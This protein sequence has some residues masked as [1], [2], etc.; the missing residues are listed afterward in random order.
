[1]SEDNRDQH[2]AEEDRE[3]ICMGSTGKKGEATEKE[4][5]YCADQQAAAAAGSSI[6]LGDFVGEY[7]AYQ[8]ALTLALFVRY[9][10][11]GLMA[12]SGPLMTPDVTFYCRLPMDEIAAIMP[13]ITLLNQTEQK[14]EIKEE[15]KRICQLDLRLYQQNYFHTSNS[16]PTTLSSSSSS[17]LAN[18]N[19]N[20]TI[21]ENQVAS[22]PVHLFIQLPVPVG[23]APSA[24]NLPVP[25]A[26]G[27]NGGG[28]VGGVKN[29][30]AFSL[31]THNHIRECADFD[32]EIAQDQGRTM[33][34]EFDLVC[35]RDWLR[36]LFQSL[37]SAAIVVAHVICGTFSDKYGR[38]KAQK[39]CLIISLLAGIW[40]I[41]ALDFWTFVLA[42][43]LCSFGDLG[44]VVS[45]TTTV[46]ELVGSRYRGLSVAVVNFGF[47]LGVT[48]LP[49]I[50]AY[51][52][53]FR[54]VITF[55]VF[56]HTLTIPFILMTNESVRWLLTNRRFKLAK[57]ELKRISRWNRNAKSL[58][59]ALYS[60]CQCICMQQQNRQEEEEEEKNNNTN[61]KRRK[62]EKKHQHLACTTKN[63]RLEEKKM[64][65]ILF[66]RFINQIES[67]DFCDPLNAEPPSS[68]SS[69]TSSSSSSKIVSSCSHSS[70]SKSTTPTFSQN[71]TPEPS[72]LTGAL[73]CTPTCHC[74]STDNASLLTDV[75]LKNNTL[76]AAAATTTNDKGK[77]ANQLDLAA[78][79]YLSASARFPLNSIEYFTH[80]NDNKQP[81]GHEL[82]KSNQ[83]LSVAANHQ[84]TQ[85]NQL[86][87]PL[88]MRKATS[89]NEIF[90]PNIP[91][92]ETPAPV[93]VIVVSTT[94]NQV[95]MSPVPISSSDSPAP[96]SPCN[97]SNSSSSMTRSQYAQHQILN[98]HQRRHQ[99][100]DCINLVAHQLSFVTRV[101]RLFKDKKLMIAV[102][103]IVWT[104]F[105][106]ELQYTS[107]II[108]NLEVGEDVYL[109]YILGG[110][111]EALAAISASLLL[112]YAPRR[113]SLITFWLLIS[114]SCFGLSI[115]HIDSTWAVWLLALA[116]FSQSCL[117]SIASVAAYE[118]FPTFLRQSGSGLVF[119]L[120]MLGS[121]FAPL[122]FAEFDD[123]AGMDRVLM[124]F[125]FSSLT[126]AILIYL[127]LQ[128]T[129]DCELK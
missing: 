111:M 47:A 53:D 6:Q 27:A 93:P 87:M 69:S 112:S 46:V 52:E 97:A 40:S 89:F 86:A 95:S 12:N 109:N 16:S 9:V 129:R 31:H 18:T 8:F 113:H 74:C 110:C 65:N 75:V 21:D 28:G 103:T 116:K 80:T 85:S 42:R 70:P 126:A 59:R 1:M 29:S 71:P 108:I 100:P 114:L 64:F 50:V 107:Y 11:L 34:S 39:L 49:Y 19:Y 66:E 57:K 72:H 38:F 62:N 82:N 84:Q 77:T 41:F 32:Y 81:G 127:F 128:E 104:T 67:Q 20:K 94:P 115:A 54:L 15:F 83:F 123:Q 13:N 61:K 25:G 76:L 14:L 30:S 26:G 88:G 101:S 99:Q 125:S 22:P 91:H 106:S 51:F 92:L 5:I 37:L 58:K 119:T 48:I 98:Q 68:T 44:L 105:N 121:V 63:S 45:M 73:T 79:A 17:L 36:S 33:T 3:K 43:A 23:G 10:F 78:R 118:S 96:L 102:F 124:T 24:G 7:G 55:T 60:M 2:L 4:G 56:C 122:I 90:N 120:G 35:D 117:S